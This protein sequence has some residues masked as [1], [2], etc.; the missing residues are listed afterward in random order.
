MGCRKV[1]VSPQTQCIRLLFEIPSTN[2][3]VLM[4]LTNNKSMPSPTQYMFRSMIHFWYSIFGNRPSTKIASVT[5][6]H[7]LW[8]EN[9][10]RQQLIWCHEREHLF[11]AIVVQI[12]YGCEWQTDRQ[13]LKLLIITKL[14][15]IELYLS[16]EWWPVFSERSTQLVPRKQANQNVFF[17]FITAH[18]KFNKRP[19]LQC[20]MRPK[21]GGKMHAFILY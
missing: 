5:K 1:L 19:T 7:S 4:L 17:C 9:N 8:S 3:A 16:I 14:S 12:Y 11:P 10:R 18:F 21:S 6:E 13:E 20:W 2:C 15:N